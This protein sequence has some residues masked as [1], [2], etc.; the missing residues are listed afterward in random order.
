MSAKGGQKE[1]FPGQ[2]PKSRAKEGH[3]RAPCQNQGS[4]AAMPT[5]PHMGGGGN[6]RT[7]KILRG[8]IKFG[9]C[10]SSNIDKK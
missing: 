3:D 7:L 1:G 4:L 8:L 2:R 9:R 5:L 10:F 6:V